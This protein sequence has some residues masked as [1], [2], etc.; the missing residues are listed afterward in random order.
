LSEEKLSESTTCMRLVDPKLKE[1]GW[2]LDN[3]VREYKITNGKIVP[4][5]RNAKKK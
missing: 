1:S 2:E 3:I 4:E 5:G